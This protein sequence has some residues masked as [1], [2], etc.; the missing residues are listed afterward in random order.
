VDSRFNLHNAIINHQAT[1]GFLKANFPFNYLEHENARGLRP[2]QLAAREG[3]LPVVLTLLAAAAEVNIPFARYNTDVTSPLFFAA[4]N[5]H[6]LVAEII[7]IFGGD[8]ISAL[9]NATNYPEVHAR[10]L[11]LQVAPSTVLA[12]LYWL[13]EESDNNAIFS[14][15][16]TKLSSTTS[17]STLRPLLEFAVNKKRKEIAESILAFN[18]PTETVSDASQLCAGFWA[19]TKGVD[20]D[21]DMLC[22]NDAEKFLLLAQLEAKNEIKH[23]NKVFTKFTAIKDQYIEHVP[24]QPQSVL[25]KR[26]QK[27]YYAAG[28]HLAAEDITQYF[29]DGNNLDDD[30]YT[31]V[32]YAFKAKNY[33]ALNALLTLVNKNTILKDLLPRKNLLLCKFV[34]LVSNINLYEF[35]LETAEKTAIY[36]FGWSI[37]G[38]MSTLT[39]RACQD[40]IPAVAEVKLFKANPDVG[41][42]FLAKSLQ[43]RFDLRFVNPVLVKD[44]VDLICI[45]DVIDKLDLSLIARRYLHFGV[46]VQGM[47]FSITQNQNLLTTVAEDIWLRMLTYLPSNEFDA[48][49]QV[50][51]L[52]QK[53]VYKTKQNKTPYRTLTR[54]IETLKAFIEK[55]EAEMQPKRCGHITRMLAAPI[56]LYI[57]QAFL[58]WGI[59]EAFFYEEALSE[60]IVNN[61]PAINQ[62]ST[63]YNVTQTSLAT[64]G[65]SENAEP[66][67]FCNWLDAPAQGA[68][69]ALIDSVNFCINVCDNAHAN[70]YIGLAVTAIVCDGLL[71]LPLTILACALLFKYPP[72]ETVNNY[73]LQ[74]FSI[75]L[76]E[77]LRIGFGTQ[78]NPD[79]LGD[80]SA[81]TSIKR[82][83]EQARKKVNALE[84][85]V[86]ELIPFVRIDDEDTLKIEVINSDDENSDDEDE[87][88][89]S[90]YNSRLV[91]LPPPQNDLTERLL[92]A[93]ASINRP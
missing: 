78:I 79:A 29:I 67:N 7:M 87:K 61:Y 27:I 85:A 14:R 68:A 55:I 36:D 53:Y 20:I 69:Q 2:L 28:A 16:L 84:E 89:V 38:V 73:E 48:F 30:Y 81:R 52:A 43:E 92:P 86:V 47:D 3:L 65:D 75:Q 90:V 33:I 25:T 18:P 49:T 9:A 56:P 41:I 51:S 39:S 19:V 35:A 71:L 31:V 88:K 24:E 50:C 82:V 10:L 23:F 46:S 80:W 63:C 77:M 11:N 13:I 64:W 17:P 72:A 60:T 62:T 32:N 66:V 76:R 6:M 44:R 42:H 45:N 22:H 74:H 12:V 40:R 91:L 5:G 83:L 34:L 26:Q 37:E 1:A 15:V 54:K 21:L 70:A 58:V 59:V 8:K 4:Q 57:I 93:A